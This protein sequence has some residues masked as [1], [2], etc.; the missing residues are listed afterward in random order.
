MLWEVLIDNALGRH[1]EGMC[2][3]IY[4]V[5][6]GVADAMNRVPTAKLGVKKAR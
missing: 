6:G 4:D 1:A 5:W 2:L 3:L